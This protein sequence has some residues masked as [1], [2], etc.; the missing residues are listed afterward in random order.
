VLI[1]PANALIVA[2]YPTLY[3]LHAEDRA[4]YNRLT[5]NALSNTTLL[6]VPIALGCFLFPELGVRLFNRDSFGPAEDNLRILSL[7]ILL[8]YFSMPIS[9]SLVA[10]G[11]QR[12][13]A[14]VQLL[15]VAV[16]LV[17]DPLLV[18]WFQARRGNG[19]LGVCVSAVLSEVIMVSVGVAMLPS[20]ILDRALGRRLLLAAGAG[21]AMWLVARLLAG[22]TPWL[23]APLSV[24]GYALC[25]FASGAIG[26]SQMRAARAFVRR[27]FG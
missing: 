22:I 24:L 16:S 1:Y 5:R 3:R 19:G 4:A 25:L 10:A 13:W 26:P 11:R 21:G 9:S 8:C 6:V 17:A 27:R 7:L 18:P 15:C 23:T 2:L 14:A 12:P 20:G